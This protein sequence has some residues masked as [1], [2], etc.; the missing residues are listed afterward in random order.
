MSNEVEILRN[1]TSLPEATSTG[2]QRQNTNMV[3]ARVG[4]DMSVVLGGA[5]QCTLKVSGPIDVNGVLYNVKDDA[6]LTPPSEG[7]YYI[8][9]SG[10][11]DLLTPTLI[12]ESGTFDEIKNAR[13]YTGYRVLNW[14]IYYDGTTCY[15]TRLL[16]PENDCN[17]LP[18]VQASF[19]EW[20]ESNG[21]WT[22]PRSKFYEIWIT[23]CGETG[24]AGGAG[25]R[26]YWT[27]GQFAGYIAALVGSAGGR[28]GSTGKIRLWIEKGDE[29][30]ATFTTGAGNSTTFSN[31]VTTLVA[32]NCG[33]AVTGCDETIVAG[34]GNI[35]GSGGASFVA[36]HL[37][38]SPDGTV[39]TAPGQCGAAGGASFWGPGG[40]AGAGGAAENVGGNGGAASAYGAGGGSGGG[41]GGYNINAAV[42]AGGSGGA[43]KAGVIR[44]IG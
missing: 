15:P 14:I 9:L 24:G 28:A 29:W 21:T 13:Y 19:D 6:V 12:D 1:P 3:A 30:T 23:G 40:A 32:G 22:C 41:G 34:G 17:Y 36:Y 2:Y 18:D 43:G 16:T 31:G 39:G 11:G 35:G 10:S 20:I 33:G 27:G 42:K 37:P 38:A 5:G 8:Y 7:V 26:L 44:I 25:G 4:C